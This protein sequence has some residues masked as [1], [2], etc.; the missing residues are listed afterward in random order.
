MLFKS[1]KAMKNRKRLR[2]GHRLEKMKTKDKCY[3]E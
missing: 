3:P 2:N 1:I